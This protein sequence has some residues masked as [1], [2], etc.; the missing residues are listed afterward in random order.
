MFQKIKSISKL[1]GVVSLAALPSLSF[2]AGYALNEQS[3]SAMGTA[4]AGAAA[5]PE[6]ATI[7]F[8]NPAGLTH[9]EKNTS[10]WWIRCSKC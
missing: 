6:N 10:F 2:S 3:A 4:N 5:N 8:F 7:L 9:L 1:A